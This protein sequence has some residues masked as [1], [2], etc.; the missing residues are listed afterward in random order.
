MLL[1]TI[2]AAVLVGGAVGAFLG[3]RRA[4]HGKSLLNAPVTTDQREQLERRGAAYLP[5][6]RLA[7]LGA[8]SLF[9]ALLVVTLATA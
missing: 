4:E 3:L 7:V 9:V 1:A 5:A 2:V 8:L 6:A